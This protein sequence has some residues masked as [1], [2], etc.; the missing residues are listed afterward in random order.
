[1]SRLRRAYLNHFLIQDNRHLER[2]VKEYKAYF[3]QERPHQ[4]I[5]QRIPDHYDLPK[6]KPT[7]GRNTSHRRQFLEDAP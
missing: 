1:M 2:V 3:N 6:S 4:S 7:S 5:A